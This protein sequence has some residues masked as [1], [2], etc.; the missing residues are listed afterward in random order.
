[1]M[2]GNPETTTGGRALKFYS[3]IRIDIRRI[4]A[5]KEGEETVGSRT[6]LKVVKNKVAVPFRAA[7][8]DIMY[9]EGISRMGDLIDLG[10]AHR[11]IDKSGSWL[12]FGETRIGQGRENAKQFLRENRDIQKQIDERLRG[13][14]RLPGAGGAASAS[15]EAGLAVADGGSRSTGSEA[16]AAAGVPGGRS[17][18]PGPSASGGAAA[19][20][21]TGGRGEPVGGGASRVKPPARPS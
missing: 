10:V 12:S 14:L 18:A 19:V 11:I 6:K 3:S 5:I 17:A 7:E 13:A 4:G 1:V 2:F 15:G 21:G 16:M 8:F 20:R 9:G